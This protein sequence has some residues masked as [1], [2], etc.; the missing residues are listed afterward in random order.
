MT[1]VGGRH[2]EFEGKMIFGVVLRR[3]FVGVEAKDIVLSE[4]VQRYRR[5]GQALCGKD[6]KR[7]GQY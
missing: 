5:L 6:P 4:V 3:K 1:T 7:Q 2:D